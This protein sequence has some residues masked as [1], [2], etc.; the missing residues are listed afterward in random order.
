M[1]LVQHHVKYKEIHGEDVVVM[2]E[3]SEHV[4][5]HQKLRCEGKCNIP[6]KELGVISHNAHMRTQHLK[7]KQQ[8][9][10]LKNRDNIYSW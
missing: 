9:R 6:P 10:Y 5:L 2:M 3:M 1:V 4:K 8:E 7:E